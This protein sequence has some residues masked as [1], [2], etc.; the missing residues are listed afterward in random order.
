MNLIIDIGNSILKCFLFENEKIINVF[1]AIIIDKEKVFKNI[2]DKHPKIEFVIISNVTGEKNLDLSEFFNY[3]KII[4]C[5]MKLNLPFKSMYKNFEKIGQD[6]IALIAA[7]CH[8]YPNKNV[9]I[10]DLGTCITYDIV[11]NDKNYYGGSIS[12][13]FVM[14]YKSLFEF[15]KKLPLLSPTIPP[16]RTG[17]STENSIHSG[18]FYGINS[19]IDSH[20]EFYSKKFNDLVV[21][22]TGGDL[23]MLPKPAKNGIFANRDFLAEG[24]N[25]LIELNRS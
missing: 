14:R 3:S 13:G 11:D 4:E 22:L 9:L 18:V 24:L 7:A 20:I 5:S 1:R 16:R 12:P 15:T 2:A 10:V 21:V 8:K 23:E 25:F 17:N 6:R 19:E